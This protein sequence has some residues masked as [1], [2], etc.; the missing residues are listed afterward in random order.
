MRS[1]ISQLI[2]SILLLLS[3]SASAQLNT[4]SP[5][6]RFGIGDVESQSM[7]RSSAMGG[8]SIGLSLPFE[9][10]ITNPASFSA[11]PLQIFLFSAGVKS[12]QVNYETATETMSSNDNGITSL[13]A[14]FK[15]TKFWAMSFGVNP[16]SS[17]GYN[18]YAEDSVISED[19]SGK[20][21]TNYIGTGGLTQLYLGNSFFYKGFS[22][23][24]NISYYWGPLTKKTASVLIDESYSGYMNDYLYSNIGDFYARIG[25]QYTDSLLGKY[26]FTVGAIYENQKDLKAKVTRFTTSNIIVNTINILDTISN[27]TIAVGYYGLPQTYGLGFSVYSNKILFGF[28]YT[29]SKW[30]DVNILGVKPDYY[31][32]SS[33]YAAGIDYTPDYL[34]K[35]FFKRTSYRVGARINYSNLKLNDIQLVDKRFTFGLGIPTKSGSKINVAFEIGSRGTLDAGLIKENYYGI[36]LN[37][38]MADRWFV[39]RRFE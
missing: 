5:Y 9:I 29:F 38:S 12:R 37:I 19:Y 8:I 10:N 1:K 26:K 35:S 17:I 15:V 36:N 31:T 24:A 2:F 34:S 33:I 3:Y 25:A 20:V 6:S 28:D 27:D 32:N 18:V 23:G 14:A 16:V 13:N 4:S 21:T 39:K 7:G 30:S 22:L 11:I